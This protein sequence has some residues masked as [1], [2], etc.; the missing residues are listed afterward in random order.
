MEPKYAARHNAVNRIS[1]SAPPIVAKARSASP[2]ARFG[3]A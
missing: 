3:A 1:Q 2:L